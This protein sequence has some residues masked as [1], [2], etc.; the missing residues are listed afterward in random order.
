MTGV[1][2]GLSGVIFGFLAVARDF[3]FLESNHQWTFGT[4][5]RG[6]KRPW[7][8]ADLMLNWKY[9]SITPHTL[10]GAEREN[11]SIILQRSFMVS[12]VG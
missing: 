3:S 12:V 10:S 6:T 5:F 9:C 7:A 11:I 1:I 8:H 2:V 4:F